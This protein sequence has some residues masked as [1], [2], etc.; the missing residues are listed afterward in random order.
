MAFKIALQYVLIHPSFD[1]HRDEYLHLDQAG[2]RRAQIRRAL[3]LVLFMAREL[4]GAP[5]PAGLAALLTDPSLA[6]YAELATERL[7]V[8]EPEADG[9]VRPNVALLWDGTSPL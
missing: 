1:L 4:L 6:A 9:Q 5:I 3:A 8:V 7:L 2:L